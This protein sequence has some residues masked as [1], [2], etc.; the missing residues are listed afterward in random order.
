MKLNDLTDEH[1]GRPI[2]VVDN[3]T[4]L[5]PAV[6]SIRGTLVRAASLETGEQVLKVRGAAVPGEH[7]GIEAPLLSTDD[8]YFEEPTAGVPA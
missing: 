7:D 3:L 4:T 6:A 2:L 1:L 5:G 8:I